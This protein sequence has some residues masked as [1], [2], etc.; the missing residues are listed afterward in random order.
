MGVSIGKSGRKF[1]SGS[2][3]PHL[4][5]PVAGFLAGLNEG[6]SLQW[7]SLSLERIHSLRVN[8]CTT[9]FCRANKREVLVQNAICSMA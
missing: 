3:V 1:A 5:A 6:V 9:T 8:H 7:K 2:A 4:F